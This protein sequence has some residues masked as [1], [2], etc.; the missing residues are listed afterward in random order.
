MISAADVKVLREQTGAGMM[1]CKKALVE[2]AGDRE[3]AIELLKKKGILKAAARAGREAGEGVVHA[4][5]HGDGKIGVLLELN[6]ETDFVARTDAFK[7]LARD[8]CMQVAAMEPRFIKRDD[9]SLDEMREQKK[10]IEAQL[11]HDGCEEAALLSMIPKELERWI[12]SSCLMLQA[13]IREPEKTVQDVL[14]SVAAT[15]GEHVSVK[16][17]VRYAL[18]ASN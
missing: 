3:A 12:A 8:L 2:T 10:L 13:S 7:G 1:D 17:F 4:Y 15:L 16:R 6:C 5:I 9:I 14:L 18:G 11:L